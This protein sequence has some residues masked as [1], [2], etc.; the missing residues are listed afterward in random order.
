MPIGFCDRKQFP[1]WKFQF[2]IAIWIL[3]SKILPISLHI[4]AFSITQALEKKGSIDIL[5]SNAAVNPVMGPLLEVSTWEKRFSSW[6]SVQN[7]IF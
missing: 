3:N 7:A 1:N 4:F 5:V 2:N 6:Y